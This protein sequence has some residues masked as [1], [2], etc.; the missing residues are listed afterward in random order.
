M[1]E[2]GRLTE[3]ALNDIWAGHYHR[4]SD[5]GITINSYK[6]IDDELLMI[7]RSG[8]LFIP[9][10]TSFNNYGNSNNNIYYIPSLLPSDSP[11]RDGCDNDGPEKGGDDSK[12]NKEHTFKVKQSTRQKLPNK[13]WNVGMHFSLFF[14]PL[15]E[16]FPNPQC[17][18]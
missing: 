18:G 1:L 5:A 16:G 8:L 15:I 12:E 6:I 4:L 10:I 14:Y 11:T 2:Y 17:L 9:P 3:L 7:I 13:S